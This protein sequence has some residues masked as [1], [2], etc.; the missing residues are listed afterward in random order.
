ME[1]ARGGGGIKRK[2]QGFLMMV[3]ALAGVD[4]SRYSKICE[5]CVK[6]KME[7]VESKRNAMHLFLR[8]VCTQKSEKRWG[9]K[10]LSGSEILGESSLNKTV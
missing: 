4:L 9:R 6:W 1:G 3:V 7:T 2:D 8:A 5:N 10:S